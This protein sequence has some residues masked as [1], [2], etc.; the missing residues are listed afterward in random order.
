[1]TTL[2]IEIPERGKKTLTD[3]VAQLGGKVVAIDKGKK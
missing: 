3:L 1:M 2:T